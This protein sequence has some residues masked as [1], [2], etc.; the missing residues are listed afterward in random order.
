VTARAT[1]V[2]VGIFLA[3]ATSAQAEPGLTVDPQSPAGVE[4][5]IPL[6]QGRHHGGGPGGQ[7]GGTSPELFGNGIT[8]P[9]QAGAGS[10]GSDSPSGT[11]SG[12]SDGTRGGGSGGGAGHRDEG[13]GSGAP[14][15]VGGSS[16]IPPVR[17]A[18]QF[19]ADGAVVGLIAAI[20]V[21]GIGLG[22]FLR[23]RARRS[24]KN[25]LSS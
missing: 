7:G 18:A 25:P 3:S 19:S 12:K 21:V 15:G 24:S 8:P 14:A 1:A 22:L 5:A 16:S 4:Y 13:A 6:D 20:L 10:G 9:A 2:A 11:G 17:A 23:L